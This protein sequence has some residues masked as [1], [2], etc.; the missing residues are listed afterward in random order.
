[1]PRLRR[2]FSH[3]KANLSPLAPLPLNSRLAASS[4]S[5][6]LLRARNWAG[7]VSSSNI[8]RRLFGHGSTHD[9][10]DYHQQSRVYAG[11][12]VANVNFHRDL[13]PTTATS[14]P[15]YRDSSSLWF[16]VHFPSEHFVVATES[17]LIPTDATC[18]GLTFPI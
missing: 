11:M 3:R 8:E 18:E 13:S 2:A 10:A 5:G 7:L 1:M 14:S 4:T 6:S 17:S 9:T 12:R 15:T 16:T